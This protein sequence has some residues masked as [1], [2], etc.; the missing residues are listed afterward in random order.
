MR[1]ILDH[2][3]YKLEGHPITVIDLIGQIDSPRKLEP[4]KEI[5]ARSE[6]EHVAICMEKAI[7]INSNA[8]GRLIA[9]HHEVENRG[10]RMF[11]V[12]PVQGVAKVMK[13]VG[14]YKILRIRK[15]IDE[16]IREV[17]V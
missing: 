12:K 8:C 1:R 15:S 11:I 2:R 6:I 13:Q 17:E 5:V 16:V 3:I 4:V 9:L 10:F 7:Y 14:C